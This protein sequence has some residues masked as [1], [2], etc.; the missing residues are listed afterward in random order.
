MKRHKVI[1]DIDNA[2][3]MP[4]RDIDDGVA[5]ALALA[6][7]DIELQGCTTCG[8]NCQTDEST[9]NT[10]IH[11]DMADRTEI[12]VAEG[13]MKPFIQNVRANFEFWDTRREQLAHLWV[14][15]L[16]PEPS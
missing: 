1:L 15:P 11:L 13:L 2:T 6:S 16:E 14:D 5:L 7:P 8:G 4:M 9:R 12:P 3:G 10:H